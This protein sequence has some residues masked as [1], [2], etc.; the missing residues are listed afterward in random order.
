MILREPPNNG[1]QA[2]ALSCAKI[3]GFASKPD[4]RLRARNWTSRKV[5]RKTEKAILASSASHQKL[6]PLKSGRSDSPA[7]RKRSAAHV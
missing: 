4:S 6:L 5:R 7:L 1:I 2:T 3:G